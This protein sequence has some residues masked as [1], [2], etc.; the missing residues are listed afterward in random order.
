MEKLYQYHP[1]ITAN[2][3]LEFLSNLPAQDIQR[4]LQTDLPTSA[5]FMTQAMLDVMANRRLIWGITPKDTDQ[6]E[7]LCLI[8]PLSTTAVRLQIVFNTTVPSEIL[9]YM[10]IFIRQQ[11]KFPQITITCQMIDRQ[12]VKNFLK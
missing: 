3:Q 12:F 10:Q 7:G 9:D 6:F 1:I 2:Y 8:H 4:F 11:L 5:H